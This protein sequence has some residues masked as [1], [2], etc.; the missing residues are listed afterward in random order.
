MLNVCFA[1]GGL[2][3]C[4]A[5]VAGVLVTRNMD[6]KGSVAGRKISPQKFSLVAG[7]ALLIISILVRVAFVLTDRQQH[8]IVAKVAS[9]SVG[10]TRGIAP[11]GIP[12][13]IPQ[14]LP[15]TAPDL[16]RAWNADGTITDVSKWP[17]VEVPPHG[18]SA[19]A[20]GAG[21]R[22]LVWA[23]SGFTVYCDYGDGHKEV[24][25]CHDGNI[26]GGHVH[27]DG[28]ALLYA[29]YAYAKMGEK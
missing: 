9:P 10:A 6:T 28:D 21:G 23:G 22:H 29:S 20:P 18:D 27:G 25:P 26:V 8:P 11:V 4:I 12:Q 1:L 19:L 15:Q 2:A 5:L 13:G 14:A 3:I 24:T 17:T 7:G 16:P